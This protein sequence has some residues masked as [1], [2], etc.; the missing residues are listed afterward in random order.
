MHIDKINKRVYSEILSSSVQAVYK[1]IKEDRLIIKFLNQ[2]KDEELQEFINNGYIKKLELI[3][4]LSYEELE[5]KLTV[6]TKTDNINEVIIEH[7]L[8]PLREKMKNMTDGTALD[9]LYHYFS[10]KILIKVLENM[11]NEKNL[12]SSIM[13]SKKILLDTIVT[14]KIAPVFKFKKDVLLKWIKE[15]LSNL[16]CYVLIHHY[17]EVLNYENYFNMDSKFKK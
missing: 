16:E 1:W 11:S 13:G 4:N 9:W 8:Y 10:K 12:N 5:E 7:T 15:N 17:E 3:K 6:D 2:F 14:A